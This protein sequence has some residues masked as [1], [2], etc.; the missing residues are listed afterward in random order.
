MNNLLAELQNL[1]RQARARAS[2]NRVLLFL[3]Q[4]ERFLVCC[5][6]LCHA[7]FNERER[8]REKRRDK[9]RWKRQK[10]PRRMAGRA[11]RP[12]L[13]HSLACSLHLTRKKES[14]QT[15]HHIV[16]LLTD[17]KQDKRRLFSLLSSSSLATRTRN[18]ETRKAN[19]ED[20]VVLLPIASKPSAA[21]PPPPFAEAEADNVG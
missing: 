16:V 2:A 15:C 12:I 14:K 8:E 11:L 19:Y 6:L 5:C 10:T 7:A 17:C 9:K 4:N 1:A 20:S 18:E 3:L 13:T 21:N